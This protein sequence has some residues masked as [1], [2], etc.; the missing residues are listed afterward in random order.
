M[1]G[2]SLAA[3]PQYRQDAVRHFS[4]AIELDQW[5]TSTYF[6]FGE[7]YEVMGLPWRAVPLYRRILEIDPEHAKAIERLAAL[8][9]ETTSATP[10]SGK[11]FL[12]RMLHRKS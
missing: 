7:L 12:S 8:E 2:R 10:K 6:Q 3:F 5:N 1:L 11:S 4:M 9:N